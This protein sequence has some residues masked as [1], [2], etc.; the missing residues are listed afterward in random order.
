MIFRYLFAVITSF[1]LVTG[2]PNKGIA[3]SASDG[4][5]VIVIKSSFVGYQF[6]GVCGADRLAALELAAALRA[7][8]KDGLEG[9]H[10]LPLRAYQAQV[11]AGLISPDPIPF[12]Q[13]GQK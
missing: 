3:Q 11:D 12:C 6:Q 8:D 4:T 9:A 10:A 7:S 2:F 5:W 1:F 13:G